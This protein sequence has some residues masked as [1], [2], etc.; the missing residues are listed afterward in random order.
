M[1]NDCFFPMAG[2]KDQCIPCC[3]MVSLPVNID[4]IN[5]FSQKNETFFMF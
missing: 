3:N 4:L 1:I 2:V 5:S